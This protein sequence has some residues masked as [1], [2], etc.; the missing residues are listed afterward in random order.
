MIGPDEAATIRHLPAYV[1][2]NNEKKQTWPAELKHTS[3]SEFD[4]LII[5]L[6]KQLDPIIIILNEIY[7]SSFLNKGMGRQALQKCLYARSK[8]FADHK[9]R[10]WLKMLDELGYVHAGKTRQGS[11]ITKEGELFLSYV[12]EKNVCQL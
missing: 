12:K 1:V 10:Q 5:K 11:I 7:K 2:R 3:E 6:E 9:V 4:S 8:D